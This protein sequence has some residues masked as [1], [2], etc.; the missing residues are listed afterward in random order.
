MRPLYAPLLGLAALFAP[1]PAALQAQ[2]YVLESP[3]P[4]ITVDDATGLHHAGDDTNYLYLLE[5]AGLIRV[6]ENRSTATA[7]V[8]LD[9]TGPVV[10]GGEQ[11]LLGLAFDPDYASNGFFYVNYTVSNPR[12]QRISRFTRSSV[13]PPVADPASEVI[14]YE[15][16]PALAGNTNHNAGA[17]VF[18][19]PEGPGGERYLYMTQGDGGSGGDPANNAQNLGTTLGKIVRLD[20]D[21][22]GLPLDCADAGAATLPAD[23]PFV[24]Q[25]G[26]CDEV[27]AYGLRNPYRMSYDAQTGRIWVADVGQGAWEEV[28]LIEPGLN[29]GWRIMEGAH[30]FDPPS[31]CNQTGLTLPVWEY[32][33]NGGRCSIT[34]GYVYRGNGAPTL[35]GTYVYGDFCSGEVWGLAYDGQGPPSNQLLTNFGFGLTTFGVDQ[36]GELY[37]LSWGTGPT[38]PR[39]LV[40]AGVMEN[41]EHPERGATLN[42]V[43]PNPVRAA[44]TL[45]FRV[46]RGGSA[47]LSVLDVLGREA[48]VLFDGAASAGA[49]HEVRLDAAR[50]PPGVYVARLAADGLTRTAQV[51]VLR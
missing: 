9:I 42:V 46:T 39:R 21:G 12:R 36:N 8:F 5:Q 51:T 6:F 40:E 1:G 4:N 33:H 16:D 13:N 2:T 3:F 18:G 19:P 41:E 22:G 7:T 31:G 17:I 27:Y 15:G 35:R 20:V 14:L 25:A 50:L 24:G 26:A 44:A 30:C 34:G 32:D 28:D 45:R 11:G 10:S 43:G 23:N 49:T 38:P 37:L 47:R 29:Y 48:T